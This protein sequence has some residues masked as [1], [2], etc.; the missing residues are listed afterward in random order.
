MPDRITC[1]AR[2]RKISNADWG[3]KKRKE[4]LAD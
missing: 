1:E 2:N 4:W 3:V